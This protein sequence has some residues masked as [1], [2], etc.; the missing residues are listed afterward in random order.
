TVALAD[1]TSGPVATRNST[2]LP[3]PAVSSDDRGITVTFPADERIALC[4][5]AST[6]AILATFVKEPHSGLFFLRIAPP[7]VATSSQVVASG[8]NSRACL[9]RSL[10]RL[11]YRALLVS[12]VGSAP[13]LTPPPFVR[14][15]PPFRLS[16]W[17]GF[18]DQSSA[19]SPGVASDFCVLSCIA[20]VRDTSADKL[21]ARAIPY[22]F[23]GFPM[24]SSDYIFFHAPLHRSPL[25]LAPSPPPAPAPVHPTP[26]GPA[27]FGVSHATPLP[28][29][30]RLV[31]SPSPQSS[32]QSPRQPLALPQQV[33]VDSQGVG[34]RGTSTGGAS[35]EGAGAEGTGARGASFGVTRAEGAGNGVASS[36]GFRAGDTSYGGAGA[37][38]ATVGAG[39]VGAGVAAAGA[40][41]AAAAAAAPRS[42]LTTSSSTPITDY[43]RATRL[44]ETRI[45]TCLVT[46]PRASSSSVSA[47]TA[48]V[49]DF[50]ATRRRDYA[51]SVVVARPLS[52]GGESALS[53]GVLEDKQFELEFLAAASPHLFVMLLAPEG[54][55]DAL[56]IPTPR[57]YR[58]AVSGPCASQW[59]TAMDSEMTSWRST[60]TY[61]D[62]VPPSWANVVDDSLRTQPVVLTGHCDSSYT[63]DVETE[64]YAG[65]MAA[66]E[67]RS[68]PTLFTDN[69]A[70]ILLCR[71]P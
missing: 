13:L 47:L 62:A 4:T 56:D 64:I 33:G 17:T 54:D 39:E 21:S 7:Q 30:A 67:L 12:R 32:P 70:M 6:G 26:P 58:E 48:T 69:K 57:T 71:Q 14:P 34:V 45:L 60:G 40:A 43:Y 29:V 68:A 65:A 49:I 15:P 24:D 53:C 52:V 59:I 25:F 5:D 37:G 18:T 11:H 16:I 55:P 2:T 22:V 46:D 20:L 61:I 51:I 41:A 36:R 28:P 23:L 8:Q 10:L 50:A 19:G 38:G 1:P 27:P 66:E 9:H 35:S 42:S 3:C 31:S 63:D 44:V